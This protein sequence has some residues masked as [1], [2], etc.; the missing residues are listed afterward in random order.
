MKYAKPVLALS[1][2]AL[3]AIQSITKGGV[4]HRDNPGVLPA[5][6]SPPAY[7]ADE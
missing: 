2:P 5:T 7:E 6:Y 4:Q 1:A 3:D